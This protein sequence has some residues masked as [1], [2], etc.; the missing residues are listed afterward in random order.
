M[1]LAYRRMRESSKKQTSI[2]ERTGKG[3]ACRDFIGRH[4]Y[5]V[6][7]MSM[8]SY[9]FMQPSCWPGIYLCSRCY[10]KRVVAR[11]TH[12]SNVPQQM[13]MTTHYHMQPSC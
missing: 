3:Y 7:Q 1:I 6:Q 12:M 2:Y 4:G 9:Y 11:G 8:I 5:G 10:G 13:S